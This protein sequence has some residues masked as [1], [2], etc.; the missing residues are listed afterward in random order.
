MFKVQKK[1]GSLQ[2]F[3]RGKII[4]GVLRSGATA[5]EAEKVAAAI[6]V[7]LPTTAVE[8]TVKF[9]DL[10]SKVLEVLRTINPTAAA[11]FEI[12]QKPPAVPPMPP[13]PSTV[14]TV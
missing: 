13:T 14:P 2:D 9:F 11:S 7:W 4:N 8:G 1:D 3:D 12:Y 10:R 6:D 5:E